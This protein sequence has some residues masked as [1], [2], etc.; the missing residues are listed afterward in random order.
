MHE[1]KTADADRRWAAANVQT[2]FDIGRE[3]AESGLPRKTPG[4]LT[5]DEVDLWLEGHDSFG[6]EEN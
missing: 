4:S 3:A 1:K 5:E 2:S 6:T